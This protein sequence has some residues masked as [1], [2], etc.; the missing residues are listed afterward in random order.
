MRLRKIEKLEKR[1]QELALDLIAI[2]QEHDRYQFG[3]GPQAAESWLHSLPIET[4]NDSI[5]VERQLPRLKPNLGDLR[6]KF[7]LRK[8]HEKTQHDLE[9]AQRQLR[10]ARIEEAQVACR[11]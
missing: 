3:Q 1:I 6:H 7:G 10:L 9:E 11:K 8:L 4:L 2:A 5:R